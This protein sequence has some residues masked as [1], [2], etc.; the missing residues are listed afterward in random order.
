ME[1]DKPIFVSVDSDSAIYNVATGFAVQ[2]QFR[3][4][5]HQF[6]IGAGNVVFFDFYDFPC[7]GK[8]IGIVPFP[9]D[10]DIPL[11]VE[12]VNIVEIVFRVDIESLCDLTQEQE[13]FN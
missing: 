2:F 10:D 7:P 4:V 8:E 6:D 1:L 13:Y 12:D 5:E 9:L 3:D 11:C